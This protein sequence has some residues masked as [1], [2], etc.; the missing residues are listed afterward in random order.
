MK[1]QTEILTDIEKQSTRNDPEDINMA[2]ITDYFQRA[3][4]KIKTS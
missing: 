2:E 4:S 3:T 1:G